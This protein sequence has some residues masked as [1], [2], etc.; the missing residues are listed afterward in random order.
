M[1]LC[2]DCSHATLH[3]WGEYDVYTAFT[4]NHPTADEDPRPIDVVSGRRLCGGSKHDCETQR[5]FGECG[6]AG[7]FFERYVPELKEVPRNRLVV[8]LFG[9]ASSVIKTIDT[10]RVNSN[11]GPS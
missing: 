5:M 4:C 3:A 9:G 1:N 11:P 6:K 2:K 7:K 8:W 10:R